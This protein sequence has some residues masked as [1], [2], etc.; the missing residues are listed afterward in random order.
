MRWQRLARRFMLGIA[1][2]CAA[3]GAQP[4]AGGESAAQVEA[5][6]APG[7][8]GPWF[9]EHDCQLCHQ[10]DVRAIG[11]AYT[12]IAGRYPASEEMVA[13]LAAHVVDGSEGRW[14][15]TPMT[16]HADLGIEQ[17]REMVKRILALAKH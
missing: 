12:D 17:A 7:D 6:P 4:P 11:P 16:P 9:V 15:D 2:W 8:D 10:V 13:E 5:A 3:A 1:A 14:G